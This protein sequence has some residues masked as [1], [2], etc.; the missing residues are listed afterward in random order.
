MDGAV[1]ATATEHA[2]IRRVDDGVNLQ[3]DDVSLKNL[4]S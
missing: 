2:F 4:E 3:R 1:H